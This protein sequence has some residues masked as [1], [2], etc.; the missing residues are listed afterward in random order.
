ML[1]IKRVKKLVI[2]V[3]MLIAMVLTG[4]QMQAME[5][6]TVSTMRDLLKTA[7]PF[8]R[9]LFDQGNLVVF[10]EADQAMQCHINA[11][12]VGCLALEQK[13]FDLLKSEQQ[14]FLVNN[15]IR[16]M[17]LRFDTNNGPAFIEER[18]GI[19]LSNKLAKDLRSAMSIAEKSISKELVDAKNFFL[20]AANRQCVGMRL[21]FTI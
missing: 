20:T 12:M 21:D 16:S 7:K 9:Q 5:Q 17:L 15:F 3:S 14:E 4:R 13:S 19:K 18:L 1:K 6:Q 2:S 8:A 10:D 11:L